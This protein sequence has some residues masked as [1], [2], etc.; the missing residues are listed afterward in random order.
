MVGEDLIYAIPEKI[1]EGF[2]G[3]ISIL[4]V[5]GFVVIFY[6]IFSIIN[7]LLYRK[8]NKEIKKINDNLEE[9]KILLAK[10]S[11]PKN[12]ISRR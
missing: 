11:A 3:L 12:K 6:V 8:K 5:V 10:K 2:S 1:V 7:A 9:I 4:K